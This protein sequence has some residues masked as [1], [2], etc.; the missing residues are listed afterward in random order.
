MLQLQE[1]HREDWTQ[2][3]TTAQRKTTMSTLPVPYTQAVSLPIGT[4]VTIKGKPVQPFFNEPLLQVDFH[5]AMDELSDIAFHFKVYFGHYVAMNSREN[6][7]WKQEVK[8]NDMPFE[9]GKAFELCISA[10]NN[11]YQVSAQGAPSTWSPWAPRARD[12]SPRP[13]RNSWSLSPITTS[14]SSFSSH[15]E[16]TLNF[17]NFPLSTS[18]VGC[19]ALCLH[20]PPQLLP[21][22]TRVKGGSPTILSMVENLLYLHPQFSFP[23]MLL[24]QFHAAK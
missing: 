16:G 4:S 2:F 1:I 24:F 5:T 19:T 17:Y 15:T 3:G 20:C 18:V 9:D 7:V 22:L 11:G 12:S 8:L 21:N 6:R 23:L 13:P 10:V 14:V